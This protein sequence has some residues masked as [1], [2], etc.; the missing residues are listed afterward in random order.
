MHNNRYQ[1]ISVRTSQRRSISSSVCGIKMNM[2]YFK[3]LE[4]KDISGAKSYF[5]G[6]DT[7][8]MSRLSSRQRERHIKNVERK[9][10]LQL[11]TNNSIIFG[12]TQLTNL[13]TYEFFKS[14][15][16]LLNEGLMIPSLRTDKEGFGDL[17]EKKR[18]KK[19]IVNQRTN[20]YDN[21]VKLV[22]DWDL[23]D[24]SNWFKQ[25]FISE[26]ETPNSVLMRNLVDVSPQEI[27]CLLVAIKNENVLSRET[28]E[29]NIKKYKTSAKKAVLNYRELLYHI[30]GARIMDCESL[31]PQEE[32]IDYSL[33]DLE[34]RNTILNEYQIFNKL[35]LSL[36]AESLKLK[37]TRIE[38]FD[39][40]DFSDIVIIRQIIDNNNF[41]D[42]Y[43]EFIKLV[44]EGFKKEDPNDIL[45]SH[46]EIMKIHSVLK[47]DFKD[48][49]D[50]ELDEFLIKMKRKRRM[51]SG[52]GFGKGTVSILLGAASL[53]DPLYTFISMAKDSP[54]T[55]ANVT[56]IASKRSELERKKNYIEQKRNLLSKILDRRDFKD[57]T[58]LLDM[59]SLLSNYVSSDLSIKN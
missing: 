13:Y 18:I 25:N 34:T 39:Y 1:I 32:L 23:I 20:F 5:T 55:I 21:N 52:I 3:R 46:N 41:R 17:F 9:L 56:Q 37:I 49:I 11:L 45:Y 24:N 16:I 50:K 47:V 27:N 51:Q 4:T 33:T 29:Q 6:F 22:A 44:V 36:A 14:H 54:S 15:P 8:L 43:R 12:A 48:K 26:L 10:K 59:V 35:F 42:K 19:E 58:Y 30:S 40:L 2:H 7:R 38:L 28:I 57:E 31:I 53:A